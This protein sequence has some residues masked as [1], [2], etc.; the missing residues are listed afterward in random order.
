MKTKFIALLFACLMFVNCNSQNS[1][2]VAD[3]S[4]RELSEK[5]KSES[6]SQ[7]LDVRT[8][9]EYAGGHIGNA[10]NVDWNGG[11]FE[12][13]VATYDK[14][15]PIYV[16]CK[17]GG[18]SA[19]AANKLAEMGFTQIYN[20]DGGI[21][22]WDAAGLSAPA[23]KIIGMCSQ[24]YG[25]LIKSDQKVLVNFYADWCEPC[26]KMA[27]Y[28]SRLGEQYKGKLLVSRLNADENKTLVREMKLETLPVLR[29]YEN[30]KIVWQHQGFISEQEL[31]K[32]L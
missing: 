7:L 32:H 10:A 23:D 12:T 17:V 25:E 9:E 18:R 24:E 15:K 5:L 4:A 3:I 20:L 29:L 8:P 31:K 11:H 1:K 21:M 6:E 2:K 13:Q 28:M 19:K 27:P 14:N 16:Y 26:K 30:G 22:K